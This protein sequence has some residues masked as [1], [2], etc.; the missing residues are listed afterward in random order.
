MSQSQTSDRMHSLEKQSLGRSYGSAR[1]HSM[2]NI[3]VI[4]VSCVLC[5]LFVIVFDYSWML[6]FF[7]CLK[8]RSSFGLCMWSIFKYSCCVP[9]LYLFLSKGMYVFV[10]GNTIKTSNS[11]YN[12]FQNFLNQEFWIPFLHINNYATQL[13]HIYFD[14]IHT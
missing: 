4:Y 9:S 1:T 6:V 14:L 13:I 7:F 3:Q 11:Y 2:E 5:G 10:R 12:N 8:I